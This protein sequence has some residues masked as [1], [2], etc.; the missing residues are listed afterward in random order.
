MKTQE[1]EISQ[2]IFWS[3]QNSREL[4]LR[5]PLVAWSLLRERAGRKFF[6]E[7]ITGANNP[8]FHTTDDGWKDIRKMFMNKFV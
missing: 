7:L 3:I 8:A 4:F 2:R 1:T 5:R 6:W